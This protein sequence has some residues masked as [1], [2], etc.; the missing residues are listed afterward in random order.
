MQPAQIDEKGRAFPTVNLRWARKAFSRLGW[1]VLTLLLVT[2][3]AAAIFVE[4][5]DAVLPGLTDN[6]SVQLLLS[7]LPQYLIALPITLAILN[8]LRPMP[9]QPVADDPDA[10]PGV[11][12]Y[13]SFFVMGVPIMFVGSLVGSLLSDALSAGQGSNALDDVASDNSTGGIILQF[14]VFV[15][16]APLVEEYVFRKQIIDRT[17]VYGEG[18][19]IVFSALIFGLMHANFYQ[20]FYAFGWGLLWGYVY[21][22]TGHVRYTIGLHALVNF[23]GGIVTPMM[24]DGLNSVPWTLIEVGTHAERQAALREH[25]PMMV[26][27][28]VYFLAMIDM[29][30]GGVVLLII[31]RHRFVLR[32]AEQ[33]LLPSNRA[34]V[35][36][37]NAGVVTFVVITA[38]LM[39]LTLVISG[40][41]AY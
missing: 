33:E 25:W 18:L 6:G 14:V 17:R 13:L 23:L 9:P 19:A 31:R 24:I 22:R 34:R 38:L 11:G 4:G 20:F 27:L 39:V 3:V 21:L 32:A 40:L 26:A 29:F 35:A 10:H 37:G 5:L 8:T 16:L 1:A 7:A 36:F 15:V 30:V 28:A 12:R 41:A 2:N